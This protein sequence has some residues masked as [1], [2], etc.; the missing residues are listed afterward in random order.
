[1]IIK[2]KKKAASLEDSWKGGGGLGLWGGIPPRD[3]WK[4]LSLAEIPRHGASSRQDAGT[5][6]PPPL[7]PSHCGF[8]KAPR[9]EMQNRRLARGGGF[10][11][12]TSSRRNGRRRF[13]KTSIKR[14][15]ALKS[16]FVQR[17][18]TAALQ[19]GK[20]KKKKPSLIYSSQ[21]DVSIKGN[22]S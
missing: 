5:D 3:Q 20:K 17:R 19:W 9:V 11:G 2:K 10:K 22:N 1:M 7:L 8:I 6:V 13:S 12:K 16:T 18:F 4:R 14:N 15:T 21:R